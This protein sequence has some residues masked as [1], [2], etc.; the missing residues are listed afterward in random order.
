M[1]QQAPNEDNTQPR[2]VVVVDPLSTGALIGTRAQERGYAVI[3]VWSSDCPVEL[4]THTA[5]GTKDCFAATVVHEGSTAAGA[6]ALE[7]TAAKLRA[8]PFSIVAILCGAEPGVTL[9]DSLAEHMC[10]RGNGTALAHVRRNKFNQSEAV[11]SSG[12]R[13]VKQILAASVAE[14]S[15]FLAELRPSP[16]RCIVKPVESAGSEDVKLCRSEEE[17][18]EHVR[19][20]LGKMNA[21][22]V[23]NDAVL[24]QEFLAGTEYIVDFVSCAGVH[25]CVAVWEYDKRP[26]NGG[27]FVYFGQRPL[28]EESALARTIAAYTA[29]VLDA[30]AISN[31][32]THSEVIVDASGTPCLV[33]CNCRTHGGNGEF[34][35]IAHALLGYTQVSALLDAFLDPPAFDALPPLPPKFSGYG[36]LAFLASYKE[37]VLA[38]APGVERA[39]RALRSAT[40][41]ELET[42]IG[43][44]V[45]KTVNVFTELGIAHLVH[46]D[47]RVV[48]DDYAA[49]HELCAQDDFV[50][51]RADEGGAEDASCG[52]SSGDEEAAWGAGERDEAREA[53]ADAAARPSCGADAADAAAA[54]LI[55]PECATATAH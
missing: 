44:R 31:G 14:A 27:S 5:P 34:E 54:D 36:I 2:A 6:S 55:A 53:C 8:L 11:R 26:L 1:C 18:Y 46:D 19:A 20:T 35:P 39:R 49:L 30:L 41:V 51:V 29:G 40:R 15:A 22:G 37:G 45:V 52:T 21:L 50:T 24:V 42:A 16:F 38:A 13:A 48:E 32:A 17:A 12:L 9:T 23:R 28:S 43:E 4:R 3:R 33:E 7:T 47:A 25:K 10:L